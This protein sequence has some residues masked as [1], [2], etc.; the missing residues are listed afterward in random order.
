MTILL[1]FF[2]LVSVFSTFG[3]YYSVKKNLELMDTIENTTTMIDASVVEL[4]VVRKRIDK[5]LKLELFS[6]DPV[7]RELVDDMRLARR[8]VSVISENL[9]GE[10]YK[11][12]EEEAVD[13]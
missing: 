9:T 8:L 7:V 6:D 5:K 2:L 3:L 13:S 12:E 10:K 11:F 4:E 1:V